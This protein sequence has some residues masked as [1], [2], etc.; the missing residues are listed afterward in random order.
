[1]EISGYSV[2]S[3][4]NELK[5][6]IAQCE[7]DLILFDI[8]HINTKKD[9]SDFA[10]KK[11]WVVIDGEKEK[12]KYSNAIYYRTADD[13]YYVNISEYNYLEVGRAGGKRAKIECSLNNIN[14]TNELKEALRKAKEQKINYIQTCKNKLEGIDSLVSELEQIKQYGFSRYEIIDLMR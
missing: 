14:T 7:E 8:I 11:M 1:M 13:L 5:C 4:K 10:N 3:K 2:N 12:S 9:G 6:S